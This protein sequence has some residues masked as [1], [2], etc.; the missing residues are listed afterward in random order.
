MNIHARITERVDK[1][2]E[3]LHF[4][5]FTNS[6]TIKLIKEYEK[7]R[8]LSILK[9][10]GKL[11]EDC[12]WNFMIRIF[13]FKKKLAKNKQTEKINLDLSTYNVTLN[14]LWNTEFS[15]FLLDKHIARF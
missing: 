11:D 3:I 2:N 5:D 7:L 13:E 4:A 15:Q 6:G 1:K 9:E 12:S 8:Y 10:L 14:S